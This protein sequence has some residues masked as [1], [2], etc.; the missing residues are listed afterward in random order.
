[1][2]ALLRSTVQYLFTASSSN[3]DSLQ[4]FSMALS[5]DNKESCR[6]AMQCFDMTAKDS[7]HK[8]IIAQ[9]TSLDRFTGVLKLR[10]LLKPMRYDGDCEVIHF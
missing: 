7:I 3:Q 9:H 1:M 6:Y 10:L 4:Y 8:S 2:R 5:G